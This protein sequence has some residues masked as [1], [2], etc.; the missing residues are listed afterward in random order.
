MKHS[1]HKIMLIVFLGLIVNSHSESEL[2]YENDVSDEAPLNLQKISNFFSEFS[3]LP[4]ESKEKLKFR[5]LKPQ[6][7]VQE[8]KKTL[9]TIFDKTAENIKSE[10]VKNDNKVVA[11]AIPSKKESKDAKERVDSSKLKEQKIQTIQTPKVA[12]N[13]N[14]KASISKE[15]IPAI[16]KEVKPVKEETS[17]V[18]KDSN[19][20][21]IEINAP[22][23]SLNEIKPAESRK[24]INKLKIEEKLKP[25]EELEKSETVI[26]FETA[27]NDK[28]EAKESIKRKTN[29]SLKIDSLDD[30]K[31]KLGEFTFEPVVYVPELSDTG[32][33]NLRDDT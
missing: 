9:P 13:K 28:S 2:T 14:L 17:V 19:L 27:T 25:K 11:K 23:N 21:K 10:S 7:E 31:A 22:Q 16:N 32:A 30:D 29:S 24:S 20:N 3:E 8:V 15:P 4:L 18:K 1:F 26:S 5:T 33:A 12:E 6:S